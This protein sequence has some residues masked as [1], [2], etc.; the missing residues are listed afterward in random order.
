MSALVATALPAHAIEAVLLHP[1]FAER[2]A[3]L[4]HASFERM[5]VGDALGTDCIIQRLVEVDGRLWARGFTGN[6]HA[7]EDWFGWHQPV[8]AP[9]AGKV[10]RI[11]VN[12]TTNQPGIM[13]KGAASFIVLRDDTG[14]AVLLAHVDDVRVTVGDTV[15]AGQ[16]IALVGNN[17]QSRSPHIHVGAFRGDT[18]LQIRFDQTKMRDRAGN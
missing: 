2:Y 10:V 4:E 13:G 16:V 14:L 12:P 1:I 15:Q 3:S 8:L 7:N 6:G 9:I 18:P 17:G 11:N 5:G